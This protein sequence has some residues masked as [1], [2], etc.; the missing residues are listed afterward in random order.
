MIEVKN[1]SKSIKGNQVLC[2][3]SCCLKEGSV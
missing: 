1:I 2:N 3:V